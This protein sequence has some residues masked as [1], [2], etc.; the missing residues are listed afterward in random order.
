ML[1]SFNKITPPGAK[2]VLSDKNAKCGVVHPLQKEEAV[3]DLMGGTHMQSDESSK[4][5]VLY[6]VSIVV[7]LDHKGETPHTDGCCSK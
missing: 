2:F 5:S 7:V 6:L 3:D 1:S 4:H